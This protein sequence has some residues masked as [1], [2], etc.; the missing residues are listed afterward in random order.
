MRWSINTDPM[1]LCF[2]CFSFLDVFVRSF[3]L[4]FLPFLFPIF[5][6]AI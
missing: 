2:I 6:L 5:A 3:I 1:D 4:L